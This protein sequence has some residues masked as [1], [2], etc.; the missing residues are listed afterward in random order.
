MKLY[1]I[2]ISLLVGV[3]IGLPVEDAKLVHLVF[4]VASEAEEHIAVMSSFA[5]QWLTILSFAISVCF[6]ITRHCS[7]TNVTD[8]NIYL[9]EKYILNIICY[10]VTSKINVYNITS[11]CIHGT[12][13]PPLANICEES[14]K[15]RDHSKDF[16]KWLGISEEREQGRE[17]LNS[18]QKSYRNRFK[19]SPNVGKFEALKR[20]ELIDKKISEGILETVIDPNTPGVVRVHPGGK[21]F[22]TMS[23]RELRH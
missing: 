23:C 9:K 22:S 21:S 17:I 19:R 5:S 2:L 20:H 4:F 1:V 13:L 15:T 3:S 12:W 14:M 10:D 6:V 16:Y 8:K 7:L 18:Y 11:Y